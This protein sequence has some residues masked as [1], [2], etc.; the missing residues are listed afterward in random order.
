VSTAAMAMIPIDPKDTEV[1]FSDLIDDFSVIPLDFP[2]TVD[3]EAINQYMHLDTA[4]LLFECNYNGSVILLNEYGEVEKFFQNSGQDPFSYR[5][6]SNGRILDDQSIE[7]YDFDT[8]K[9]Y[10]YSTEGEYIDRKSIAFYLWRFIE[11]NDYIYA[12]TAKH[13][14]IYGEKKINSDIIILDSAFQLVNQ[15]LP[16]DPDL[17]TEVRYHTQRPFTVSNG[18]VLFS[19][20]LNDTV[21]KI[22]PQSIEPQYV[23]N[24][25]DRQLPRK[26]ANGSHDEFLDMLINDIEKLEDYIFSADILCGNDDFLVFSFL[27]GP[28]SYLGFY[29]TKSQRTA[30]VSLGPSYGWLKLLKPLYIID[31]TFH[32]IVPLN[33]LVQY[34]AVLPKSIQKL[35]ENLERELND[36]ELPILIKYKLKSIV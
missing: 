31:S 32:A 5:R 25:G 26:I 13:Q 9:L 22:T 29:E 35:I 8:Q 33:V 36:P 19:D 20:V 27:S 2:L 11:H 6:L 14:N 21:Y 3:I 24:T 17:F 15:Y 4:V 28:K 18:N 12:Y 7:I 23:F 1:E 10:T 34:R 30:T 16:F